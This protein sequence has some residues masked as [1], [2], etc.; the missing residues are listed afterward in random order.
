ME[1]VPTAIFKRERGEKKYLD[2]VGPNSM[3][4][5]HLIFFFFFK[6]RNV[7]QKSSAFH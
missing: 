3:Q 2:G 6:S 5:L 7:E 1:E 4:T